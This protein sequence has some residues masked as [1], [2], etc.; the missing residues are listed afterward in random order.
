MYSAN[1][2]AMIIS[3]MTLFT[4]QVDV[5]CFDNLVCNYYDSS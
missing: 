1:S 5:L 3:N 2:G 4:H